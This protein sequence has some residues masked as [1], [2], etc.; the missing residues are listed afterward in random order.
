MW[1]R[2]RLPAGVVAVALFGLLVLL[3][4]L[5]YR[6]LGQISDADRAQRRAR[7]EQDAS[8]FA[9]D[10]DRELAR[11]FLLFQ[12]EPIGDP[13]PPDL[14][15]RF[16]QRYD[17]WQASSSF[18]RLLKDVYSV[19]LSEDGGADLRRY[20]PASRQLEPAAWPDS[21]RDWRQHLGGGAGTR[22]AVVDVV[23]HRD[24]RS[25]GRR[26]AARARGS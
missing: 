2:V 6:W 13:V 23:L 26:A 7:L 15:T 25:A 16:A 8:A 10:F 17:H 11:A 20:N 4:V 24:R 14:A 12:S 19:S 9:Q 22:R 18:P 5:Q 1:R 3:A 21:L